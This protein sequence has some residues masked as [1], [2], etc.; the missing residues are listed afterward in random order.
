MGDWPAKRPSVEPYMHGW[1]LDTHIRVFEALLRDRS[2]S[3]ILELGSW[4]G[5]STRWLAE[6]CPDATVY[7]VDLWS[8]DF[9]LDEQRDHYSTMGN[10]KLKRMLKSHPLW[11]TFVAN[12]W[13][14]KN[15]V[16]LRMRTDDG[17]KALS[18][19]GLMPDL[20]YVDADHHYQPAKDDIV[21]SLTH[22]PDAI[23]VGDDYGHYDS[24]RRAVTEAALQFNKVVHVD[25]NH[26]W[27]LARIDSITGRNF[28]PKPKADASFAALL[29]DFASTK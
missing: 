25:Q 26:C 19:A 6:R 13:D 5:A 27:A 7:A 10:N 15:V 29:N 9:I 2:P 18:E 16:P 14:M 11:P 17:V 24:V 23:I 22:F 28:V 21:Q 8:D 3:I 12:L 1:F 20:V 4:Y